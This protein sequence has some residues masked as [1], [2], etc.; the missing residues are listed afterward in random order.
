VSKSFDNGLI[1]GAENHLVVEA[2]ARER[3][4]AEL[5]RQGA[6]VLTS[7]E[8]ARFQDEAVDPSTG[9]FT[10]RIVGQ[11][12]ATLARLARIERP[13]AIQLLVVPTDSVAAGNYLAAEKLAPVTSLFTV[14]NTDDGIDTCRR[15]LEIDGMGHT[16]IIHTW[17]VGLIQRF[18]AAI[19][20]S[21]IIVNAPATQGLMGI[22]T[23][24][25]PSLTLGSGTWGGSSTTNN[26]TYK[27]L[28]NIKR[29]AYYQPSVLSMSAL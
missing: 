13:Y 5:I 17:D 1:C 16:A 12:A 20:A 18:S 3:L 8:S 4:I 10:S 26:V 9:R 27:D 2:S 25:V 29:V 14:A 28:L 15:L 21:R 6:A 24:L 23:G 7:N 22:A 19:P 11:D